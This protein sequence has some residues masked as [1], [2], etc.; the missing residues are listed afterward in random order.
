MKK[1]YYWIIR[2]HKQERNHYPEIP[3]V[4]I[5]LYHI[6]NFYLHKMNPIVY[7]VCN[8][9]VLTPNMPQICILYVCWLSKKIPS[10]ISRSGRFDCVLLRPPPCSLWTLNGWTPVGWVMLNCCF[11]FLHREPFKTNS[12]VA[13]MVSQYVIHSSLLFVETCDLVVPTCGLISSSVTSHGTDLKH[14]HLK[15]ITSQYS[16]VQNYKVLYSKIQ[17]FDT[18]NSL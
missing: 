3:S 8:M 1:L 15:F 13:V 16:S 17:H 12:A 2:R 9:I 6:Y 18:Q 5:L 7:A 10:I 4:C 14:Y 11:V